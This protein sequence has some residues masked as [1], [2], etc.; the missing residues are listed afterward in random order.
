MVTIPI[1]Q[2][3]P[4]FGPVAKARASLECN[5][6]GQLVGVFV[7]PGFYSQQVLKKITQRSP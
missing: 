1:E 6:R 3:K 7:L 2:Q 5:L 4:T